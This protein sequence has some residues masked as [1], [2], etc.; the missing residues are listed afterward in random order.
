MCICDAIV[1]SLSPSREIERLEI[2]AQKTESESF[3]TNEQDTKSSQ[4]HVG[5][6]FVPQTEVL[7]EQPCDPQF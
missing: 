4:L 5:L 7:F 3:V 1:L 2:Q 6:P